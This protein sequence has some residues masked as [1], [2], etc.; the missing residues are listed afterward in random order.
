MKLHCY[1]CGERIGD[2]VALVTQ[3]ENSVDRVF[4]MLP[5][6]SN[7]VDGGSCEIVAR[8]ALGRDLVATIEDFMPSLPHCAIQNMARLN[9]VLLDTAK[10]WK[11]KK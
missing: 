4:V 2:A 1:C 5:E 7:R 3:A 10:L 11:K 6:H 9:R 8:E